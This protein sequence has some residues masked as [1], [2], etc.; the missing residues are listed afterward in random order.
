MGDPKLF[1]DIA[2]KAS[3]T[4]TEFS[5]HDVSALCWGL[6]VVGHVDAELFGALAA[7]LDDAGLL[8]KLS[9]PLAAEL[10]WAFTAAGVRHERILAGAEDICVTHA[11]DLE[12]E[13]VVGFAWAF[14]TAGRTHARTVDVL[15]AYVRRFTGR[16]RPAELRVLAWALAELGAAD[17][18]R[19]LEARLEIKRSC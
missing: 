19:T 15:A 11:Q 12:T 10:V 16:F 1:S 5:A 4:I 17:E 18:A 9:P 7:R 3:A 2:H 6:A 14:A 13:D 8:R